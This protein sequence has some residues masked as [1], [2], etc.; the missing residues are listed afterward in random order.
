[1]QNEKIKNIPTKFKMAISLST[2]IAVLI[3]FNQCVAN[4]GSSKVTTSKYGSTSVPA[5]S[6]SDIP[7]MNQSKD[8]PAGVDM[9][10]MNSPVTDTELTTMQVG[11]KNFE[12]INMTMSQLTAIPTNNTNVQT[13]YNE[14]IIQLPTDNNIKNFL[15]SMQVAITKLA[16]EYCDRL[17]E[18]GAQKSIIWPSINF[19][20]TPTQT[21]TSANKTLLIDQTVEY[22]LG[23]ISAAEK[24]AVKSEL[25]SLYDS[26][27][28]NESL[29]TSATTKKVVKGLCT[30]VLSSAYITVF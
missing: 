4:K 6:T 7:D 19:A 20:Q 29:T 10:A 9:P 2:L 13:V 3:G 8:L 21:L 28:L 23:P 30:S 22:F 15:P 18:V 12:Q 11:V 27:I 5:P 17:I 14:I 16:T 25:I 24:N 1:M 26:L